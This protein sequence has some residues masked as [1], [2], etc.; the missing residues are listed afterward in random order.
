MKKLKF[1]LMALAMTAFAVN[2]TSCDPDEEKESKQPEVTLVNAPKTIVG[3]DTLRFKVLFEKGNADLTDYRV[4]ARSN[5]LPWGGSE[6]WV[7]VE[8]SY[9]SAFS[10]N[11]T[12]TSSVVTADTKVMFFFEVKD[13]NGEIAQAT[14]EITITPAS[15]TGLSTATDFSFQ[16]A[17]NNTATGDLAL[18]GLSWTSNSTDFK[19]VL[20]P[21]TG[22]KLVKLTAAQ[23]AS[24]TTKEALAEAIEGGTAVTEFTEVAAKTTANYDIVLGTKKSDG[25]YTLIHI[26]SRDLEDISGTPTR[27]VKGQ[28]KN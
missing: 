1:L 21:A 22:G 10:L 9:S 4:Y 18:L 6:D 2:F 24:I 16:R 13:K 26:T 17:G 25:T 28:Y 15:G 19:I 8:S 11:T 14:T 20:K 23:W 3:G 27:T 7:P 12:Y 5:N